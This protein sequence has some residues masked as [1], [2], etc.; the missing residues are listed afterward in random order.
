[1][2]MT[3]EQQRVLTLAKARLRIQQ[4]G[5]ANGPRRQPGVEPRPS[6]M[7]FLNQGIASGLGAPID[8]VTGGI[9][10]G[11]TGLNMAT[12]GS[13]PPIRDP[14]GGSASINQAMR[15]V[16]VTAA[17]PDV[18]PE[19]FVENVAAGVGGAAGALVPFTAGAKVAQGMGGAAA[20]AG[21]SIMA[22]F[23]QT[24][25]RA[26]GAEL[27]A[28]GGAG[29]GIDVAQQVAPG[30]PLAEVAG[31][32]IGGGAAGL[33]P[34]LATRSAPYIPG[35]GLATRATQAAVAPF[36]KAGALVRAR[37]RIASLVEDPDAARAALAQEN[38]GGL[39]P[40]TQTG[41][42]RLMALEQQVRNTDPGADA[43]GRGREAETNRLFSDEL[44]A[45][46][47][48]GNI[49]QTREFLS[50]RVSGLVTK[51]DEAVERASQQAEQKLALLT[52]T[53][54]QSAASVIV[55]EE[56]ES[57]LA[58]ARQQE[59]QLWGAIPQSIEVPTAATYAAYQGFAGQ[60]S[61]AE[62][63]TLP[64]K[65]VQFLGDGS[66]TKFGQ[67]ETVK[68][69]HGLYSELRKVARQARA[70]GE[71]NTARI[72]D[73]VADAIVED[74]GATAGNVQGQAGA[75]LRDAIDFSRQVNQTY[76]QG[77][78]GRVLGYAKEGGQSLPA[79]L[80]LD[81]TVGRPGTRG[82][83]NLDE[84]RGATKNSPATEAAVRDYI[85][86]NV[87]STSVRNG[88]MNPR[89]VEN[90]LVR[91]DELLAKTPE[92]RGQIENA[93]L[94]NK[95]ANA[96][97]A[98]MAARRA[99]VT[100]DSQAGQLLSSPQGREITNLYRAQD[101]KAAAAQLVRQSQADTSGQAVDGLKGAFID[102][103]I[104][105]SMSRQFDEAGNAVLSGNAARAHLSDPSVQA[106]AGEILS[107]DQKARLE[108]IVDAM[109]KADLSRTAL[110]DV[111]PVISDAPNNIISLIFRTLAARQGAKAGQGTSGAS[112]LT[113]NFASRRMEAL[114]D[115]LTNNK[116]EQMIRQA[117][118]G[119]RELFDAL[120][121]NPSSMK[122]SQINRLA[123]FLM[124]TTGALNATGDDERG[125]LRIVVDGAN[126]I[127]GNAL[128]GGGL[129][130]LGAQ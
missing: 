74:I 70:A 114:L 101:P 99:A 59:S 27:A 80:T 18:R 75:A 31:A 83:V 124:G 22:P 38:I 109:Q 10:A 87:Q 82:A 46:G 66:N 112:L 84:V 126:P 64:P 123:E 86:S 90:F 97:S 111:G 125:P 121:A 128:S 16:G 116:A 35:I 92:A 33:T 89:A 25:V 14:I 49:A 28:G 88:E 63:D 7:D 107:S 56:I 43:I 119:D 81:A 51:M 104:S 57:A 41:E 12:G 30:N 129:N 32:L 5:G 29:A 4:Q 69:M 40:A 78:I 127:S 39:S 13:I 19:G 1:M 54:R 91:N 130:A 105:A 85:M 36:T 115:R 50:E 17:P 21:K 65:V 113:A 44:S 98:T 100:Q 53:Q 24:P 6:G 52:P 48:D 120:L 37:N 77:S 3:I 96:L 79:E 15:S 61:R 76:R 117:V 72:S 55:R 2:E 102:D 47:G 34:N 67:F 103:V 26:I 42:R 60:L 110:P 73:G 71:Y 58:S 108:Q 20:A 11:I 122:P 62:M 95:S 9:N 118:M 68:E 45:V 93:L 23:T 94:A 106:V 8:L